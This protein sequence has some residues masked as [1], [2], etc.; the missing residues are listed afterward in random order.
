[1]IGLIVSLLF[2]FY[3]FATIHAELKF[4]RAEV[5]QGEMVEAGI[6]LKSD[7]GE[8]WSKLNGQ[9]IGKTIYIYNISPVLKKS[10]EEVMI[11]KAKVI[12]AKKPD[13]NQVKDNV[14]GQEIVLSWN[15]VEVTEVQ[16]PQGFLFG[17]F[18]A[19]ARSRMLIWICVIVGISFILLIAWMLFKKH[20]Q[21]QMYKEKRKNLKQE[22]MS[23]KKYDDIVEI[24]KN[25]SNFLKNFPETQDSFQ[26][27]ESVLFK[28]QFKLNRT[29]EEI[30]LVMEAYRTFVNEIEGVLRGI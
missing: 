26:K 10:G 16:I 8:E 30:Q 27:L 4:E 12:F 28:Y 29:E 5:K 14:N 15:S 3:S 13:S 6:V 25:K 21:S 24:W 23:G 7:G 9:N 18:E 19:P 1:M 20:K 11:S 22:M 17:D 2:S